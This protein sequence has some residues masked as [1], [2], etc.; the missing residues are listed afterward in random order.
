MPIIAKIYDLSPYEQVDL[1]YH[2]GHYMDIH[3]LS[4]RQTSQPTGGV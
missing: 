2:F 3:K 1:A 4:H